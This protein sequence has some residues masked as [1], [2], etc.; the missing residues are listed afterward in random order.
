MSATLWTHRFG[1]LHPLLKS[2]NAAHWQEVQRNSPE[3]TLWGF[4]IL[5]E[6]DNPNLTLLWPYCT[7]QFKESVRFSSLFDV[8]HPTELLF[9][10]AVNS[11]SNLSYSYSM[12][13]G[14]AG[15]NGNWNWRSPTS[16]TSQSHVVSIPSI[17]FYIQVI[18]M[19]N[20]VSSSLVL[21]KCN[22]YMCYSA[23]L[24]LNVRQ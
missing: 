10:A 13:S 5:E 22:I 1:L 16:P 6:A 21:L 19:Q 4:K 3:Q 11:V 2:T 12:M 23:G 17:E 7:F 18:Y 8:N 24:Y 20:T 14:S 15:S 9:P